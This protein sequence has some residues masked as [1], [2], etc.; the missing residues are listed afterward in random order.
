VQTCFYRE[1]VKKNNRFIIIS[2]AILGIFRTG[3]DDPFRYEQVKIL[4]GRS[5]IDLRRTDFI[6]LTLKAGLE[7][8]L[9]MDLVR[10]R[11]DFLREESFHNFNY[12][13]REITVD[14]DHETYIIGFTQKETTE[15][16]HFNG[17]LYIDMNSLAIRAAAFEMDQETIELMTPA[18]V[19]SKPRHLE[20]IPLSA[21]YYVRYK[22]VD[23]RYHLAYLWFDGEFRIRRNDQLFGTLF[24]TKSEMAV[25]E[26]DC[27]NINKFRL[28]ETANIQNPFIDMVGGADEAFWEDFNFIKPDEPLEKAILKISKIR[29]E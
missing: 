20:V 10:N 11:P 21:Q 5:N 8:S 18:M 23:G 17:I 16:P 4:K 1:T 7:T 6:T 19:V 26:T 27:E 25:T 12:E 2:E 22:E 9:S 3:L 29:E 24:H 14:E 28:R 15:P 13:L